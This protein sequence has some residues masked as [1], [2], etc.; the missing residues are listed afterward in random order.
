LLNWNLSDKCV[1][2]GAFRRDGS[3]RFGPARKYGDFG[4]VGA[5]W[6]F[7]EE[8]L[9]KDLNIFSFGKIRSSYGIT[10]ND[11]TDN[12]AYMDTYTSTTASYGGLPGFYPTRIA[13]PNFSWE[14]NHKF[15]IAAEL[16]FFNDRLRVT[17]A[18]YRNRSDNMVVTAT[19]LPSQ[20]GFSTYTANLNALV[21]N[22]GLEFDFK[23]APVKTKN[24]NWDLS[25]N[26]SQSNNKLKSLPSEL[27]SLYGNTYQVGQS[28]NSFVVY[29]FTGFSNGV[30]QFQD[31]NGDGKITAGLTNDGYAAGSKDPK[32]YGGLSSSF[33]YKN[34]Q[35]DFLFNF[36]KQKGIGQISFPGT[37]GSQT[38]DL[39]TTPFKPSTLTSSASYVSYNQY[40]ASDANITDAS[41]IR[42]RNVSVSYSLPAKWTE[43][44]K[45]KQARL[46]IHGQNLWTITGFK[47]FDPE[48]QGATP[49]TLPPLKM[50][51][52]GIQCSF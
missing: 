47:G 24:I 29:H 43:T 12:Y 49:V 33:R 31:R 48:T 3:S 22:T 36:V 38:K 28:L 46:F 19:P 41:F 30:A 25:F 5:A 20:T 21:E 6:I 50:L 14:S 39:L 45:V 2:N 35:V 15:E 13:N 4:S 17:S 7:S 32:F 40:L 10:G 44:V 11:Q 9:I 26:I 23:V 42:L 51:T 52:A 16:G 27:S 34:L 1:I 8:S 37:L 18:W